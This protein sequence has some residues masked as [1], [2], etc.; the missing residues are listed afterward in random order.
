[1]SKEVHALD[2]KIIDNDTCNEWIYIA[3]KGGYV[4]KQYTELISQ[5]ELKLTGTVASM[6]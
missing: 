2:I 3:T 4:C 1:M 6:E 5:E